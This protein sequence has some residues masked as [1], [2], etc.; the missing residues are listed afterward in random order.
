LKSR[1][2]L[3]SR[4]TA[5]AWLALGDF[6]F[7]KDQRIDTGARI[8]LLRF[9]TEMCGEEKTAIPNRVVVPPPYAID[10]LNGN[11]DNPAILLRS[12]SMRGS[13][14]PIQHRDDARFLLWLGLMKETEPFC[15]TKRMVCGIFMA[16][17][18]KHL[19]ETCLSEYVQ[20]HAGVCVSSCR[21]RL[22]RRGIE[23]GELIV[24]ERTLGWRLHPNVKLGKG[25][26]SVFPYTPGFG[27]KH[28]NRNM[29]DDVPDRT[30]ALVDD[31]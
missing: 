18:I 1:Y 24:P 7:S 19:E 10:W 23:P 8:R 11:E 30:S 14:E 27:D 6:L 20:K 26:A 2:G 9:V 5:V 25:F 31:E 22:H 16:E 15:V 3:S 4:D 21:R 29:I 13:V 28:R 12:K 17:E